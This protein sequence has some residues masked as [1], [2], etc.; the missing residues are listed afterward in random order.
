[1]KI[2]AF[3]LAPIV[4]I[5]GASTAAPPPAANGLTWARLGQTVTVGTVRV[6]PIRVLEDSRCPVDVAC[7]W[8]GRLRISVRITGQGR[9]ATRD[10]TLRQ[11]LAVP[12]GTLNLLDARPERRT[13]SRFAPS[14]YSFGL[15]FERPRPRL[16][17]PVV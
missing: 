16:M 1:M 7:V 13:T 4:L 5:A 10:L 8:A 12:G 14:A 9:P 17:H 11:P 6:T 15:R 2:A 3:L